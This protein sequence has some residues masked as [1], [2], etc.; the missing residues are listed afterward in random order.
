[1]PLTRED[2]FARWFA[3]GVPLFL[4]GGLLLT[5]GLHVRLRLPFSVLALPVAGFVGIQI[6][7][8]MGMF[9]AGR[10]ARNR[11]EYRPGIALGMA[12]CWASGIVIMHYAGKWGLIRAGSRDY[13]PFS[14]LIL[15]AGFVIAII[16][17]F[18]NIVPR[19]N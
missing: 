18:G 2:S 4:L 13:V 10:L 11:N 5:I 6:V 8:F 7:H 1:M 16:V 3:V 14:V 17:R 12:Y 19:K 9:W 15:I